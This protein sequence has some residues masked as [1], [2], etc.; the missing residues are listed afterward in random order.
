GENR[1]LPGRHGARRGRVLSGGD[2]G[3]PRASQGVRPKQGEQERERAL[4]PLQEAVA[5]F[6]EEAHASVLLRRPL[7]IPE[8]TRGAALGSHVLASSAVTV[9]QTGQAL[10]YRRRVQLCLRRAG[11]AALRVWLRSRRKDVQH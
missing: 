9:C 3:L 11:N 7:R 8:S 4:S 10:V 5:L 6:L 2:P 1:R